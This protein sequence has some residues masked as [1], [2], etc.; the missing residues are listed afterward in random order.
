MIHRQPWLWGGLIVVLGLLNLWR[1]FPSGS[2]MGRGLGPRANLDLPE[3]SGHEERTV[4]RDLFQSQA[5]P[6]AVRRAP[7]Q[8]QVRLVPATAAPTIPALADGSVMEAGGGYRLLGIAT[9]EGASQALIARGDQL[10]Q[11][12]PGD[13]LEG[14]YKVG[15]IEDEEVHLT[16]NGTGNTLKLH[17]WEEGNKP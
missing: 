14:R 13:D 4:R 7:P 9:R 8:V 6:A 17:L 11:L 1:W 10:F 5:A 16:E 2:G 12:K 3:P 15:E